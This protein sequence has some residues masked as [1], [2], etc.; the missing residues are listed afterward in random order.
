MATMALDCLS[1][2]TSSLRVPRVTG[3]TVNLPFF[4]ASCRRRQRTSF[5]KLSPAPACSQDRHDSPSRRPFLCPAFS[6]VGS[7]SVLYGQS[8]TYVLI[9]P[10]Q[11]EE[12][13][14]LGELHARLKGWLEK[15]FK[16]LPADL[17]RY[18]C[19]D[20]AVA[21]LVRSSCELDVGDGLGSVQWFEV[22]L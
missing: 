9:E 21:H 11:E 20:D 19:L 7:R 12:F 22:H 4:T 5:I 18:N 3:P 8:E 15:H 14:T 1:S 16:E 13:V 17:C 6:M 2:C 10:G